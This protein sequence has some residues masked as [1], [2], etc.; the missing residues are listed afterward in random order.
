MSEKRKKILYVI[1]KSNWGGAQRYV[2]DIATSLVQK[3]DVVVAYGEEG[4]LSDMLRAQNIRTISLPNLMRDISLRHEMRTA[5]DLYRLLRTEK[6]HILHL[7]SSKAGLLGA[8]AGRLA[9]VPHIVFTAHAWAWNEKRP[10]FARIGIAL[11]HFVTVVLSH[12]TITV[13][14]AVYDQMAVFPLTKKKMRVIHPGITPLPRIDREQARSQ[15][16]ARIPEL[17]HALHLPWIV[18]L[19]ELHPIKGHHY[20]LR[21]IET[22]THTGTEC[23]YILIGDGE[24]RGRIH[25]FITTHSLAKTIYLTGHIQDAASLLSAFDLFVLPS[26][27]EAFGYVLL[28]AGAAEVPVVASDVGG[29]P[30][31]IQHGMGTVIPPGDEALLVDTLREALKDP[32]AQ[33]T[34]ALALKTAVHTYFTKER[35]V[36]ETEELYMSKQ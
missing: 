7:N 13:S 35:M 33:H 14:H 24:E 28:E 25:T 32:R 31:I 30:E 19:G 8:L 17:T 26:L 12:R 11:L 20:A 18:T 10:L 4:R 21:A 1:T 29:I 2:F 22:L 36:T 9:R 34:Y 5:T 15:F 3:Y 16:I 23:V 27:S 6:P